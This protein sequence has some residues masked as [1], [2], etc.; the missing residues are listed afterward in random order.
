M[1][2]GRQSSLSS[3]VD[4]VVPSHKGV[5]GK[6]EKGER[7]DPAPPTIPPRFYLPGSHGR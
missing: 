1:L 4:T 2:S 7:G 3:S 6:R 5:C